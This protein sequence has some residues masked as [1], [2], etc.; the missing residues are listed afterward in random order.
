ME[1]RAPP[2]HYCLGSVFPDQGS[3]VEV[4][5]WWLILVLI[6]FF[7]EEWREGPGLRPVGRQ[8]FEP[9]KHEKIIGRGARSRLHFLERKFLNLRRFDTG[10]TNILS[11]RDRAEKHDPYRRS[12]KRAP[13]N[14]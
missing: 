2:P 6:E 9:L 11:G 13:H 10:E 7:F 14:Q 1:N 5:I 12:A 8:I 4:Q 3:P